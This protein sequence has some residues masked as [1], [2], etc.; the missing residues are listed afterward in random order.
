MSRRHADIWKYPGHYP[1]DTYTPFFK[2]IAKV[3]LDGHWGP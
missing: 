3:K 2:V 1:V